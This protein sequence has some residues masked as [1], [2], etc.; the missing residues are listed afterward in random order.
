MNK[1]VYVIIF[2]V[3]HEGTSVEGVYESVDSAIKAAKSSFENKAGEEDLLEVQQDLNSEESNIFY[4]IENK[5]RGTYIDVQ[6]WE[7]K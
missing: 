7:L 5:T 6:R 4:C 1:Y 2:G 3:Y